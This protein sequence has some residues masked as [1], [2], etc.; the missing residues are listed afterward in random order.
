MPYLHTCT[1]VYMSTKQNEDQALSKMHCTV[2]FQWKLISIQ[3][4]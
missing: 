2:L 1:C 3:K 4:Y